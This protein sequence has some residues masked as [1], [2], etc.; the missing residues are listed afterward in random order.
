MQTIIMSKE[1]PIDKIQLC[2]V[3]E[4]SAIFA[5]SKDGDFIGMVVKENQGWIVKTGGKG[6]SHG[7]HP[8]LHQ[9]LQRGVDLFDYSYVI[10]YNLDDN[11][12]I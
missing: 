6:G 12:N 9:C 8:S 10:N 3:P 2:N 11:V 1:A 7:H 5:V 4:T